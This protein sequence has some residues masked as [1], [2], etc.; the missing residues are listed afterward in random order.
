MNRHRQRHPTTLVGQVLMSS[1]QNVKISLLIRSDKESIEDNT[2]IIKFSKL[3]FMLLVCLLIIHVHNSV[4]LIKWFMIK[5]IRSLLLICNI[6]YFQE[7]PE[8]NYDLPYHHQN[9]NGEAVMIKIDVPVPLREEPRFPKEIWKTFLCKLQNI[10]I[11]MT[12]MN[13]IL[14]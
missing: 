11:P 6:L 4:N 5:Y 7:V 3:T 1:A 13:C 12:I 14:L 2:Q 8:E 10:L 9:D